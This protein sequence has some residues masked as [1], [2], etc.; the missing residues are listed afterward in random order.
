MGPA[1]V[2]GEGPQEQRGGQNLCLADYFA[3]DRVDTVAFQLV[4]MGRR[5]SLHAHQLFKSDNY[6]DYLLF[7]GLSVESAEALAEMWHK[8]IREEL[9]IA[10]R[11]AAIAI[12]NRARP[13]LPTL[14]AVMLAW[15]QG[16]MP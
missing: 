15:V 5:A 12:M 9:G 2:A 4:T 8:R 11:D 10:D 6:R 3:S 16:T 13:W 7:H 14:L 1:D